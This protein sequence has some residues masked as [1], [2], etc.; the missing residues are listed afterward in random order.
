[1]PWQLSDSVNSDEMDEDESQ[2]PD[3]YE[4][5]DDLPIFDNSWMQM[6]DLKDKTDD[7]YTFWKGEGNRNS[8]RKAQGTFF[9]KSFLRIQFL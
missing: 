2:E 1:M 5:K 3:D 8:I 4:E 9:Q 6:I 7:F